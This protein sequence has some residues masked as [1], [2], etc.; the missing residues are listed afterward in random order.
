MPNDWQSDLEEF[1]AELEYR[2]APL[3]GRFLRF[4]LD[5]PDTPDFAIVR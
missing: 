1:L 5:A 4:D 3:Y 2:V